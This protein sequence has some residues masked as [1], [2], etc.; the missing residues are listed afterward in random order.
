MMLTSILIPFPLNCSKKFVA[1]NKTAR[2]PG[3]RFSG[4]SVL[5]TSI[6]GHVMIFVTIISD[7][8]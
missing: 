1:K 7:D 5:A 2:E 8:F 4:V 3:T 6:I